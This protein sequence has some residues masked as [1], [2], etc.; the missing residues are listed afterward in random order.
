MRSLAA[1]LT[2]KR[3]RGYPLMAAARSEARP[4]SPLGWVLLAVV[5]A[6]LV[7]RTVDVLLVL[8]FAV[9]LAVYLDALADFLRRAFG[10]PQTVGAGAGEHA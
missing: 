7:V 9:I 10:V 1:G 6:A 8:F 5:V 4:G 2:A 3:R